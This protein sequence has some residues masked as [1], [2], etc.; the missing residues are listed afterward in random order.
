MDSLLLCDHRLQSLWCQFISGAEG[1]VLQDHLLFFAITE[2][3]AC[4][5]IRFRYRGNSPAGCGGLSLCLCH[6]RVQSL[7]CQFISGAEGTVL[8]DVVDH[9]FFFAIR[10]QS[11]WCHSFQVQ[12]EQSCRMW[13]TI[14]SSLRSECRVYD[15]IHF[16][17]RG[18]SPAGC[19]GPSLLLCNHRLQSLWCHSFQVQREQ[20]CRMWWTIS[21][22]LLSQTAEPVIP[23]CFRYT[24]RLQW[25]VHKLNIEGS[26][27]EWCIS[28]MVYS[29]D[30]SFWSGTLVVWSCFAWRLIAPLYYMT[31]VLG[32]VC[33]L[34]TSDQWPL[35]SVDNFEATVFCLSLQPGFLLQVLQL[36]PLIQTSF[37]IVAVD[38][39]DVR[40][41]N[42]VLALNFWM[43]MNVIS[44]WLFVF[45]VSQL[46]IFFGK[47]IVCGVFVFYE[48]MIVSCLST[49][50]HLQSHSLDHCFNCPWHLMHHHY[51]NR[52][53][54]WWKQV[55]MLEC[56]LVSRSGMLELS[57]TDGLPTGSCMCG[58]CVCMHACV[59]IWCGFKVFSMMTWIPLYW[60]CFLFKRNNWCFDDCF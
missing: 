44:I 57:V 9:L 27:P 52:K 13:W 14:S 28:S 1:T 31:S 18:N 23:V 11:V 4:D 22:S 21:S 60:E 26:R 55:R 53:E 40:M 6:H 24:D 45:H 58:M 25:L 56:V 17:C 19:G 48:V 30:A 29:R 33:K 36:C 50:L 20:S 59:K 32:M 34:I 37:L 41:L 43:W 15:A 38:S 42:K 49:E 47:V 7:W 10:V 16:R 46:V 51:T 8:Q 12:R 35:N 39:T 3:R 2:C 5:A 54:S